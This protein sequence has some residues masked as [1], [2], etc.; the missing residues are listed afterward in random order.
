M[1]VFMKFVTSIMFLCVSAPT[2]AGESTGGT[3]PEALQESKVKM[4]LCVVVGLEDEGKLAGMAG[5]GKFI[6]HA[7]VK[8]PTF[9]EKS[10]RSLVSKNLYGLVTVDLLTSNTLPRRA[11]ACVVLSVNHFGFSAPADSSC[12]RQMIRLERAAAV[13][14]AV[15]GSPLWY[16]NPPFGP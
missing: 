14:P 15:K 5:S 2:V 3:L 1:K 11:W 4:G 7:L 6:V 12:S 9:L 16:G 10:R 13:M 8:D